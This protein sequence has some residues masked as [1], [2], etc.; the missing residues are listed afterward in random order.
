MKVI[1][2]MVD[3]E[4]AVV[5]WSWLA[6]AP[7][8]PLAGL[9]LVGDDPSDAPVDGLS[10]AWLER[11]G[12]GDALFDAVYRDSTGLGPVYVRQSC[13]SCHADDARGPG[14]VEK[15]V[16]VEADG[17]TPALDQSALPWGHTARPHVAGGATT[18]LDVPALDDLLVTVRV[19]NPVFG[20][21]WLEAID[22]AAIEAL[23][24]DQAERGE[25]ISG[26]VNRVPW[27][28]EE[29]PEARFHGYGPGDDDLV[30]RFG[31]KGRIATLDEFSA[32]AL[33][34]DMSVTSPLRP[35]ELPNPDGL[36][37]DALP[38]ED[39]SLEVV[40]LLADYMRMLAIPPRAQAPGADLFTDVGCDGCHV[41]SLPTRPDYPL[42]PLAGRSAAVYTDLLLHDLGADFSDGLV[43]Q[44]AGP[45]EWKTAPLLGLRHL[46]SYLHDGRADTV[47]DAILL[48]GGPGSEAEAS[49]AA[50]DTLPADER[51]ELLWFVSTR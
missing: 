11:F 35:T 32:D 26:R 40:N 39:V 51:A 22:D 31:L 2:D 8:D 13:A 18:P 49:V 14:I 12:R 10:A 50:F 6:C 16:V 24:A 25:G 48:H 37:D 19:P 28:S 33:Q 30:G 15:F 17:I 7:E 46:R 20:R 3:P 41:P 9:V 23:A 38:G 36:A 43:D 44:G 29:N 1:F 47:E 27:Q 42:A 4:V 34:G 5:V 45:S 21:G